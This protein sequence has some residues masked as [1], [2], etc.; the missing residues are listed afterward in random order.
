M[1]RGK[2]RSR[3]FALLDADRLHVGAAHAYLWRQSLPD[4]ETT[5]QLYAVIEAGDAAPERLA[6]A[7]A[8]ADLASVLILP[9]AR[10]PL[11]AAAARPLIELAQRRGAAALVAGDARLAR[12]LGADGVHLGALA[13]DPGDA[14]QAAR[15]IL[16]QNG[17]VGVEPGISRHDAMMLAEAGADY[18]A[19]GAPAQLKDRDK[20]RARRDELATWW[21][22]IFQVPCVALDVETAQGAEALAGAGVDFV[23]LSLPAGQS[24]AAARELVA[25][26]AA[27]VGLRETAS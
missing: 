10:R 11:D 13:A 27:A 26:I 19:F 23:G 8:A 17:I 20:A 22:E 7:F 21:A 14:Y 25:A 6:A 5:C 15:A 3:F 24:A 4:A 1:G 16:G 18:V 9:P 12:S 2:P